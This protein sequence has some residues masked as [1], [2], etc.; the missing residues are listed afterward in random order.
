MTI[1]EM[2]GTMS[3]GVEEIASLAQ[4]DATDLAFQLIA[5]HLAIVAAR[6]GEKLAGHPSTS[7]AGTNPRTKLTAVEAMF[8]EA[9][10][11]DTMLATLLMVYLHKATEP[12]IRQAFETPAAKR[13]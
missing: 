1:D 4:D 7:P 12:V 11:S 13:G 10:I 2:K 5:M 3:E 6:V 8:S 9:D